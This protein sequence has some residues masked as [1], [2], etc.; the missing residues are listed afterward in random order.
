MCFIKVRIRVY[1]APRITEKEL[2]ELISSTTAPI[3]SLGETV[4][5]PELC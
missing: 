1:R 4:Y 3:V 2:R 5:K